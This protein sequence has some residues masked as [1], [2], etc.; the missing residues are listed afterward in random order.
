MFVSQTILL[1]RAAAQVSLRPSLSVQHLLQP[2]SVD[3]ALQIP[4]HC[5]A[6]VSFG[7]CLSLICFGLFD[8]SFLSFSGSYSMSTFP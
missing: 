6:F 5:S 1:A 2:L 4:Y 3:L 8:I 7:I